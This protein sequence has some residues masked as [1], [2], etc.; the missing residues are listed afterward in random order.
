MRLLHVSASYLPAVRYG[1]TIVS[2]HGLCRAL[3]ARGHEV[4]VFTT[5]VDGARDS[6]VPHGTAVDLDGV[7]VWYFRSPAARRVYWSPALGRALAERIGGFDVAHAHAMFVWPLCA[8]AKAARGARVPYVVSPRGMLERGLVE[9]RSRWLKSA[10]LGFCG[11]QALEGAAAVHVT[12]AREAAEARAFGYTLPPIHE[13]PNG[14]DLAGPSAAPS[15]GVSALV[16]GGR[17]VLYLGRLSWKKGL[18]RL[19]EA[20]ALVPAA[21]VIIAGNDEEGYRPALDK[22][23]SRLGVADRVVFAGPVDG[24]DKQALLRGADLLVL[25]SY[26][27]NF[28]NVVVEAMAAGCPVVVTPEV[29][30][31]SVVLATGGGVVVDGAPETLARG[32][33]GLLE[34]PAAR[35]RMGEAGRAA[36]RDYSWDA[37]AAR[38]ET[39]YQSLARDAR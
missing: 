21:R 10:W 35:R 20:T 15:A 2:V 11:R 4:H 38:I 18:D 39:L 14:V 28:G 25:P 3:A 27:E 37:V 17:Y 8:M 16:A 31:G 36:A 22:L 13:V 26:S 19:L 23:A 34:N 24:A 12:S 30:S 1:G 7:Q 6:A 5:S 32:I 9:R 29:G 33:A